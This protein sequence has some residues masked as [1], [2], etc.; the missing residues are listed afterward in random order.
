MENDSMKRLIKKIINFRDSRNWG[1]TDKPE[2][3]AKSIVIEAAELLE[4]FQWGETSYDKENVQEEL[5]DV[6]IYAIAMIHDL[7]FDLEEIINNKLKKNALKY[8][9]KN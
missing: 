2:Y 4:N 1:K 5:A 3:L 6:M 7:G 9:I 8:P